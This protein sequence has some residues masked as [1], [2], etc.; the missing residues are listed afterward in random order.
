MDA[1]GSPASAMA[2]TA[3]ALDAGG[4]VELGGVIEAGGRCDTGGAVE[5][6]DAGESIK[7]RRLLED[8][9][10]LRR[11]RISDAS[12]SGTVNDD[13]Y[14]GSESGSGGETPERSASMDRQLAFNS[15]FHGPPF[16]RADLFIVA[17][18]LPAQSA[19]IPQPANAFSSG[20]R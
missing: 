13:A 15:H 9:S 5:A 6:G 8:E 10:A 1:R 19:S 16:A 17:A 7:V 14:G 11:R 2:E 4:T 18:R 12:T 20:T 3:C